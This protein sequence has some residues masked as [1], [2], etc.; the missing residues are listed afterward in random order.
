MIRTL[1]R[2]LA[3]NIGKTV[4]VRGWLHKKRLLGG[5][6]FIT[7]RDRSGL[8]QTLIEDKIEL[9]K[10]RGLQTGTVLALTGLVVSDERAPGG[11]ELHDVKV[12]VEVPVTDEPPI[13]VD[14]PISH[15]SEHLDNPFQT[16]LS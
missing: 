14:K 13:E 12:E 1:S 6:N 10:L 8:T 11:A 4:T 7:I 16:G 9:E 15:K 5:L 3:D 2:E